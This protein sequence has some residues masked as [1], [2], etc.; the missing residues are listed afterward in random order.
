[1]NMMTMEMILV[2]KMRF[3]MRLTKKA[4]TVIMMIMIMRR[5]MI[6]VKHYSLAGL[7]PIQQTA[8]VVVVAVDL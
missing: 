4:N 7:I 6:L 3:K 2:P 8:T 5:R 1:M